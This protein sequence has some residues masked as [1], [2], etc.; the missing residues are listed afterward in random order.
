MIWPKPPDREWDRGCS[1]STFFIF[2]IIHYPA[3]YTLI[4]P[5]VSLMVE[6]PVSASNTRP[7][8]TNWTCRR[9]FHRVR[10]RLKKWTEG[11]NCIPSSEIGVTRCIFFSILLFLKTRLAFSVVVR[12][13]RYWFSEV[14]LGGFSSCVSALVFL[15]QQHSH[16]ERVSDLIPHRQL[17]ILI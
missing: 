9:R 4:N 13:K 15:R 7:I 5:F 14:I 6:E 16:G 2:F 8:W 11:V 10:A 3:Y 17:S 12:M 1:S